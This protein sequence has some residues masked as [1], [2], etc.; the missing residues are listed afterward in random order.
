MTMI[1]SK[2]NGYLGQPYVKYGHP[3]MCS[4]VQLA[5]SIYF[6][7][8]WIGKTFLFLSNF[9]L[10]IL[11]ISYEMQANKIGVSSRFRVMFT[12]TFHPRFLLSSIHLYEGSKGYVFSLV[13]GIGCTYKLFFGRVILAHAWP[14]LKFKS[15]KL[16]CFCISGMFFASLVALWLR[17]MILQS[18]HVLSPPFSLSH[19]LS[20]KVQ[21]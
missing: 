13:V 1:R 16:T 10:H 21:E 4:V 15:W 19:F 12:C 5:S 9:I 20:W 11:I 2:E 6:R 3:W 14:S 7:W 18:W 8:Q 17:K